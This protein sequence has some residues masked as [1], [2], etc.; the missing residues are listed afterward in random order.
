MGIRGIGD[1]GVARE[2]F[3]EYVA[4]LVDKAKERER[5]REEDKV[6][7]PCCFPT[8]VCDCDHHHHHHKL[9]IK[10]K[11]VCVCVFR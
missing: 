11:H 1:E 10:S 6:V 7:L 3:E 9:I 5:K 4:R 8:S 2:A